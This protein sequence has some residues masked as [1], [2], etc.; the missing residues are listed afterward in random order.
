MR[1]Q[2][3]SHRKGYKDSDDLSLLI[4]H[5]SSNSSYGFHASIERLLKRDPEKV[6]VVFV[7]FVSFT[8]RL[9]ERESHLSG[10]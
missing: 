8:Q 4:R 1:I 6:H 9:Q 7:P 2:G 3:E 5:Y 10:R